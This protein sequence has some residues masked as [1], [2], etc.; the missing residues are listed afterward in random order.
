MT[1]INTCS[2]AYKKSC[3]LYGHFICYCYSNNPMNYQFIPNHQPTIYVTPSTYLHHFSTLSFHSH[4]SDS[5]VTARQTRREIGS[6]PRHTSHAPPRII[7]AG[8]VELLEKFAGSDAAAEGVA[9]L[10]E[11]FGRCGRTVR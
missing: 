8:A 2:L 1:F 6:L 10:T 11:D 3:S 4:S 9:A 5:V 7:G